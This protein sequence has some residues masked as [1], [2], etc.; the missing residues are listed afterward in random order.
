VKRQRNTFSV[1][2]Q[3]QDQ[4]DL[5][6]EVGFVWHRT[7]NA[8]KTRYD[9]LVEF[10]KE[11]GHCGV[12]TIFHDRALAEWTQRQ[13]RSYNDKE[14]RMSFERINALEKIPSWSWGKN[15]RLKNKII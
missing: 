8:W 6:D 15:D 12:S 2:K 9:E 7:N 5:L 3:T 1:G 13:R 10:Q 14:I 4:I 11:F